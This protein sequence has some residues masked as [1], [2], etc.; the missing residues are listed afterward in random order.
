MPGHYGKKGQPPNKKRQTNR[1]PLT[2][3]QKAAAK[4]R[5]KKAERSYPN[6]VDKAAV[7]RKRK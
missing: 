3:T 2:A 7:K 1:A 5:A 4:A 6:I